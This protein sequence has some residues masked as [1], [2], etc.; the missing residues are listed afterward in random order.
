MFESD[1]L[2]TSAEDEVCFGIIFAV[3]YSSITS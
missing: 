1:D 3:S 2:E